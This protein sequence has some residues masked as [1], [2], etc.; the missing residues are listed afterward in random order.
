MK[1]EYYLLVSARTGL[2]V[3]SMIR[4]DMVASAKKAEEMAD[5]LE[6][7]VNMIRVSGDVVEIYLVFFP[8][9]KE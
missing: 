5:Y 7:T 1:N 6:E 3:S 2:P 8:V 4:S 9:A